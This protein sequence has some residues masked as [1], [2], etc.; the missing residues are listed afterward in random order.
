MTMETFPAVVNGVCD[1]CH[2]P[3]D[4]G[5]YVAQPN[6][7]EILCPTCVMDDLLLEAS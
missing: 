7:D 4:A 3:F 5:D 2:A 1:V 6:G